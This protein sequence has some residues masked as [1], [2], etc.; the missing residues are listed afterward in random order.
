MELLGCTTA[1]VGVHV[2]SAGSVLGT[3]STELR[4]GR[5]CPGGAHSLARLEHL[6]LGTLGNPQRGPILPALQP[7]EF[8]QELVPK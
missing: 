1:E 2:L 4:A 6:N 8:F 5:V 3:G 7:L